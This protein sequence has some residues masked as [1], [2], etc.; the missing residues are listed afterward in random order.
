MLSQ[1]YHSVIKEFL[2]FFRDPGTRGI[3]LA[4][5]LMQ[6]L[7]FSF[8]AS[9]EVRNVDIA[10]VNA[11]SGRWSQEFIARLRSAEFVRDVESG[12]TM[13]HFS[14]A[15]D[16]QRYLLGVRFPADFSRRIESG[17]L[18][19][20][21][22]TL[23]GRRANAGQIASSYISAIAAQMNADIGTDLAGA[24]L[25]PGVELR[26]W[27]NPNLE[28][29]W[30]IVP[31][32]AAS[33]VLI[34]PLMMTSLSIARER[35][36]GTFDQLLVSPVTPGQ[37]ILGKTLPAVFAGFFSGTLITA[38]AIFGFKIPFV[39]SLGLMYCGMLCFVLAVTGIGLTVSA[40]ANTQQQAMLGT[41]FCMIP[42]MMT[43]GFVTPVEN[44]P[45]GLQAFAEFNPLKHYI[46]IVQG[47]FLKDYG[48]R[49]IGANSWPLVAIA[50][51]MLSTATL[52][53][54]SRLN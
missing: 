27:F 38:V 36:M 21:Q 24:R 47:S 32:L 45:V 17:Q 3:L 41:F 15:V 34:T 6:V 28:F 42:L 35:E 19:Q 10:L 14:A 12:P 2:T 30:F 37:I 9:M 20:V 46:I 53:L 44:M 23:D 11:D 22:L 18:A 7:V 39:G 43:S 31:A 33:M 16:H 29:F 26:H 50:T 5:P 4:A 48:W 40:L 25:A 13:Q 49:E 8:A 52:V 1:L 51:V 54:R